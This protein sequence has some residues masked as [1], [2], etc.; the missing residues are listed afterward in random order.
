[1]IE[2][3]RGHRLPLHV[4]NIVR[5]VPWKNKL[6]VHFG[7][8]YLTILLTQA[9]DDEQPHNQ[10]DLNFSD[11]VSNRAKPLLPSIYRILY[12]VNL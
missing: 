4:A 12:A 7:S 2:D 9:D 5:A 6:S 10:D 11:L 1:M 3:S 8:R